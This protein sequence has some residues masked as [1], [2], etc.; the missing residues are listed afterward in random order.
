MRRQG[1]TLGNAQNENQIDLKPVLSQLE[2][3]K[4]QQSDQLQNL[5]REI[6]EIHSSIELTQGMIDNQ[7]EELEA[8]RQEL[9]IIEEDLLLQRTAMAESLGRVRVYQETLQ[10]IQDSLQ[11]IRQKLQ[12]TADCLGKVQETGDYQLQNIIQMR[13]TVMS[14]KRRPAAQ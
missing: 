4:Q 13:Q 6:E 5:E 11:A 3:L 9:R 12:A 1:H 8:K 2:A 10:P 7:A 14:L